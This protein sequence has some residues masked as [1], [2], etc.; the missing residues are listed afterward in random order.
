MNELYDRVIAE[1]KDRLDYLVEI[2]SSSEDFNTVKS[3]N[4]KNN[5]L[6]SVRLHMTSIVNKK[7]I[8]ISNEMEGLDDTDGYDDM[9]D[10]T[11]S[12]REQAKSLADK[13]IRESD[14]IQ[15]E[16]TDLHR[17]S[18]LLSNF[19]NMNSTGFI[20]IIKK[21]D[22][23]FPPKKGMFKAILSKGNV[24]RDGKDVEQL[25]ARMV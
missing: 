25:S 2:V 16:M 5:L 7:L 17:R 15:R 12:Q 14:S 6:E 20:K 1:M 8:D 11:H 9:E 10:L 4:K 19:A 3:F 23:S 13:V 21:F 18:K 22:K 24:C